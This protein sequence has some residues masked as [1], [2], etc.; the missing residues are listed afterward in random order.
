MLEP[1]LMNPGQFLCLQVTC[2][3]VAVVGQVSRQVL[4]TLGSR[5]GMGNDSRVVILTSG[6]Q[7]V[8]A[9]VSSGY[10][11]LS[12]S[13][14]GPTSG[15]SGWVLAVVVMTGRVDLTLGPWEKCS[16]ASS[17]RLG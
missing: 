12:G 8:H 4:K 5:C 15:M 11:G 13:V 10:D 17:G 3:I 16:A 7:V 2:L 14:P 6:L 1:V 9:V